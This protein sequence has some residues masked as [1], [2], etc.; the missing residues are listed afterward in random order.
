MKYIMEQANRNYE[1]LDREY[2]QTM[3]LT[4]DKPIK[5]VRFHTNCFHDQKC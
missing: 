3:L 1:P 5:P 4:V 2:L